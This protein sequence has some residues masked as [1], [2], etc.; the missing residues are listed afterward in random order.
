M[1]RVHNIRESNGEGVAF[2]VSCWT[3]FQECPA[4]LGRELRL[5]AE[6]VDVGPI[7]FAQHG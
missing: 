6:V 5:Q 2:V 3:R 7:G 1:K 4:I